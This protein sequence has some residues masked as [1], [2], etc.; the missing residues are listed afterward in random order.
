M[1]ETQPPAPLPEPL[2]ELAFEVRV[3]VGPAL[4]VGGASE[5][6]QLVYVPIT[7]G[8][9]TGPRLC[10][11]I[12]PGGGD[13]YVDRDGV[14]HLDAR[15]VLRTDDGDLVDVR[16][17]GFWRASPEVTARLDD[18]VDVPENAYYYRTS[19]VFTTGA[20]GL[21]WLTETVFVGMARSENGAICIRFFALA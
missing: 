7:G 8:T 9:A 17:R 2:L 19:P 16:N 4:P 21:R 14:A 15:Y 1:T 6:E 10:G 5:H 18:G 3:D 20:E 11:E 12:L 13:W